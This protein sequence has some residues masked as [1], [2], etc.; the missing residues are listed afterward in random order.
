MGFPIFALLGQDALPVS[1]IA[2]VVFFLARLLLLSWLSKTFFHVVPI[3]LLLLRY[4][5]T[6]VAHVVI[7]VVN[8]LR[9][10]SRTN[11]NGSPLSCV[12]PV[13]GSIGGVAGFVAASGSIV[14]FS[15]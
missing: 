10:H 8:L 13:S 3:I 6:A 15:S 14:A 4:P 11:Q 9:S 5:L 2:F 7:V 1:Q 12:S